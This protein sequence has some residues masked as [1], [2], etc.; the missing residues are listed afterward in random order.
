MPLLSPLIVWLAEML[1]F[2]RKTPVLT[3]FSGLNSTCTYSTMYIIC[4]TFHDVCFLLLYTQS[5]DSNS[6]FN[7]SNGVIMIA[8]NTNFALYFNRDTATVSVR[9]LTDPPTQ[10]F[11]FDIQTI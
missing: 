9:E 6:L 1:F 4:D 7:I 2:L 10:N 11:K 5:A 8:R 3:V